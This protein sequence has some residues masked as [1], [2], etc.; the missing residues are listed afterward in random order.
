[1][2]G[3]AGAI[4]SFRIIVVPEMM[5]GAGE[6]K[7]DDGTNAGYRTTNG[8]YD[9]FPM[10]VVGSDAFTT[11]GFQ[12]GG[13]KGKGT[14]VPFKIADVKP[15]PDRTD[16]YGETGFMSIKWYYG[17]MPLRPERIALYKVVAEI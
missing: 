12:M 17:F 6:G 14:H 11:I 3:E 8:N 7:A 16:P 9:I 13:A 4:D 15:K 2:N 5:H 1:M 10:L